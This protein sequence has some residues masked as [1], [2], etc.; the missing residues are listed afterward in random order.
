MSSDLSRI[1]QLLQQPMPQGQPS[2]ILEAPAS[3]DLALFPI[4]SEMTSPGPR[5]P[6]GFLPPAQVRGEGIPRDLPRSSCMPSLARLGHSVASGPEP[7]WPQSSQG[8]RL[9]PL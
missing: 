4:A 1:L 8:F 7:L 6:Q 9:P 3:S 2:Y 5:L